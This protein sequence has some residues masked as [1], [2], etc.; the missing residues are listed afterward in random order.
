[1]STKHKRRI[2]Y[3]VFTLVPA[4]LIMLA[5]LIPTMSVGLA[6]PQVPAEYLTCT[7]CHNDT[8]L[9]TGKV[10]Q[11]EESGHGTGTAFM[12]E[13]PNKSCV[14]CHSGGGFSAMIAA[15]QKPNQPTVGDNNP[16]PQNCRA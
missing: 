13:G 12:E 3:M 9:I 8:T 15:G 11:W 7:E 14:G 10:A 2:K 16:T 6:D 5:V 1:M 4:F